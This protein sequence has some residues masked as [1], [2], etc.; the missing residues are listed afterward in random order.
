MPHALHEGVPYPEKKGKH[1]FNL[2]LYPGYRTTLMFKNG[3][4]GIPFNPLNPDFKAQSER[5]DSY[6]RV[7]FID[8]LQVPN[9]DSIGT[10]FRIITGNDLISF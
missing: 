7:L 3:K 1:S 6:N 8:C 2:Y 4:N 9:D 5:G 10:H